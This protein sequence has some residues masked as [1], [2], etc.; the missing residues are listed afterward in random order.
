MTPPEPLRMSVGDPIASRANAPA[1]GSLSPA[2]A[3]PDHR[4]AVRLLV[5]DAA[6]AVITSSPFIDLP[7][8][9]RAGDLLVVNDAATLPASLPA[10]TRAGARIEVRL[11]GPTAADTWRA[12][13]LGAGD[14]RT[15]TEHRPAPP[16]LARG[17]PIALG[18]GD[19]TA[20]V[21]AV[22][23]L[24]PR[25]IELRFD[26]DGAPLWAA[27]YA[28]GRPVQYAHVP[29]PLDLWSVQTVYAAR[30]W[31][32]EMP[33]AGRP[34]TWEILSALRHRGVGLAAL[35]HAAGLSATGDP[36]IDA[37][38]PLPERYELPDQTVTAITATRAAGGRVI[39]VGTTVV[40]ALEGCAAT[41][42]ELRP[43]T[44]ETDLVIGPGF[45]PRVTDA[46]LSGIHAPGE[47]HWHI[48]SA[49][50]GAPL[51]HRAA[52]LAADLGLRTH[53]LGD[54]TLIVAARSPAALSSP[55]ANGGTTPG[56]HRGL[57]LG[58]EGG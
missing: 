54:A 34:L 15:P 50:A 21:A 55:D 33:S 4:D 44:G 57:R 24:S 22:S 48:L 17:D 43:G 56:I 32:A 30:P 1:A 14:W 6:S 9:L 7:A 26:R 16:L 39:A 40:R 36:A 29:D 10:R 53:E 5:I 35:T 51:L 45:R 42:G 49:F 52:L 18:G 41:H 47:S 58:Q 19:L 8:H 38:L 28:A 13:L 23:P 37:A 2:T 20:R 11:L 25:L 27:L 12:V 31:A 3:P 46:L